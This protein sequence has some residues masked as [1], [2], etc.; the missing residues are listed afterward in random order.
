MSVTPQILTN[1]RRATFA[2]SSGAAPAATNARAAAAGSAARTSA[3]PTSAPSNPSARQRA[4]VA[5]S[6]TPDSAMTRRSSG[7]SSRSRAARSTST[8]SVRRSR[9]LSPMSRAPDASAASSSR[10]SWTSTSGSRPIS[11]ARSTSRGE[12]LRRME[13]GQQQHEVR[14]GGAQ[15]RQLDVLDDEVLGQD[16]DGDRGADRA[17]VVHR[18]AEPV[19]LAQDG[20]GRGTA[21]LVGPG[22]RDDVLVGR[23]DPSGRRR[24]ALDLGDEVEAGRREPIDDRSR[25]GRRERRVDHHGWVGRGDLGQDVGAPPLGDLGDDVP[26][27]GDRHAGRPPP[28]PPLVARPAAPRGARS[29]ARR[30][31]SAP[32]AR[33][34]PP[35]ARRRPRPAARHR[36]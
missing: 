25:S 8:S 22:A 12:P 26:A 7:T 33:S 16:R 18:P 35:A 19:R 10:A 2:G 5:G 31:W 34:P 6:R 30:R 27:R 3:S 28:P 20:D 17:Q 21:G 36:R 13:D 9:L 32:P 1:G 4:T 24:R 11:R 29:R 15:H 23:G 14:A